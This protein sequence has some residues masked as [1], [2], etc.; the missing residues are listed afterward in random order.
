[1]RCQED[2]VSSRQAHAVWDLLEVAVDGG[3][4]TMCC[5]R[6]GGLNLSG[7]I[8]DQNTVIAQCCA[9]LL[10]L[11]VLLAELQQQQVSWSS[12]LVVR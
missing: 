11:N 10:C 3:N 2:C 7:S 1:V 9:P 5:G 8:M 4:L 6:L 12:Q